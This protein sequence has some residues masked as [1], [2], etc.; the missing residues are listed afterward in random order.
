M[1]ALG[2]HYDDE[3]CPGT[4]YD[5]LVTESVYNTLDQVP[6]YLLVLSVREDIISCVD[7]TYTYEQLKSPQTHQ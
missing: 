5:P 1:A 3:A 7:T 4:E 6:V 2:L